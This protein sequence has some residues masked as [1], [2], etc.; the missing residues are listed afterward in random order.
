MGFDVPRTA[1]PRKP[2]T[3]RSSSGPFVYVRVDPPRST[4]S[5]CVAQHRRRVWGDVAAPRPPAVPPS[6]EPDPHNDV[7]AEN[8]RLFLAGRRRARRAPPLADPN[9]LDAVVAHRFHTDRVTVR[10]D[11]V[12]ALG[13]P[14]ELGEDEA[15]DRVVGVR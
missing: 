4:S 8:L 9:R 11:H 10:V 1:T 14:A 15:A 7:A 6:E 13:E 5:P 2:R 3:A 12:A